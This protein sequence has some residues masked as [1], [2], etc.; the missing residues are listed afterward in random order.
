MSPTGRTENLQF[1]DLNQRKTRTNGPG[2]LLLRPPTCSYARKFGVESVSL[3]SSGLGRLVLHG[4]LGVVAGVVSD[5]FSDH[6]GLT[7]VLGGQ[8]GLNQGR[9]RVTRVPVW[10]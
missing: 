3:A 10:T 4:G 8:S 5:Q 9:F 2:F 7:R 6:R 1:K